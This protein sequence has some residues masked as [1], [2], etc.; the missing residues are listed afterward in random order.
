[1]TQ[2]LQLYQ[3]Q[4]ARLQNSKRKKRSESKENQIKLLATEDE[5]LK[6]M[7]QLRRKD[8]SQVL[9]NKDFNFDLGQEF[10]ESRHV[11]YQSKDLKYSLKNAREVEKTL[12]GLNLDDSD[13]G[14]PRLT[15]E[16]PETRVLP[17]PSFPRE[18]N[19][20]LLASQNKFSGS[21]NSVNGDQQM[22][23]FLGHP[24]FEHDQ[25][26]DLALVEFNSGSDIKSKKHRRPRNYRANPRLHMYRSINSDEVSGIRPENRHRMAVRETR[27]P[28]M[29][30][31]K[32]ILIKLGC[33]DH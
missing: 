7:S 25:N 14:G 28:L 29:Q 26:D 8:R 12:M 27:N 30:F 5:S 3:M 32:M 16:K 21:S 10:L 15:P 13:S 19:S 2:N 22:V 23:H 6:K 20:F 33:S 31:F 4:E 1:M 9:R 11:A 17:V 18:P 24:R